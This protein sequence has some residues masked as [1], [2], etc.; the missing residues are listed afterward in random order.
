VHIENL[1]A[2][3]RQESWGRLGEE[4]HALK[5]KLSIMG[6]LLLYEKVD[7]LEETCRALPD[8]TTLTRE[9]PT[10]HQFLTVSLELAEKELKKRL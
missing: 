10:I 7:A 8:A 1:A 9:L 3:A 6:V 5:S 4:L 2:C